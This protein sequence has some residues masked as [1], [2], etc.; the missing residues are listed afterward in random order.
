MNL[1]EEYFSAVRNQFVIPLYVTFTLFFHP[2]SVCNKINFPSNEE[3]GG[4]LN[5]I[6]EKKLP[7]IKKS[8]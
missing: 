1:S 4:R 2:M 8:N 6:R 7:F 5:T 3:R